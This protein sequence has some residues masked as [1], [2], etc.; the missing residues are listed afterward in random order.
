MSVQKQGGSCYGHSEEPNHHSVKLRNKGINLG[1]Q[2]ILVIKF[3]ITI[4][5]MLWDDKVFNQK[6]VA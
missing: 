6:T 5:E 3:G 2:V 1:I 4:D